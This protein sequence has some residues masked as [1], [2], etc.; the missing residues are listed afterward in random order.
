MK[1]YSCDYG[2]GSWP[3]EDHVCWSTA[4]TQFR[5]TRPR[6]SQDGDKVQGTR[7]LH[8][9]RL[10]LGLGVE[11]L[12][13]VED[14]HPFW[15]PSWSPSNRQPATSLCRELKT[16]VHKVWI[17]Q[18]KKDKLL[19]MKTAL[20]RNNK[21]LVFAI[22]SG[23]WQFFLAF[24]KSSGWLA[25]DMRVRSSHAGPAGIVGYVILWSIHH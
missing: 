6:V 11:H 14:T 21:W 12:T 2:R 1:P 13:R 25:Y 8:E 23:V 7:P 20:Y 17:N 5:S 3:V 24:G 10:Q 9:L 18:L 19:L 16:G 15:W 4:N 22:F